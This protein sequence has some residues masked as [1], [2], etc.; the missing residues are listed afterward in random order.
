MT[1]NKAASIFT[2]KEGHRSLAESAGSVLD[3]MGYQTSIN[4]VGGYE[5]N[6]YT[7]FYQLF[8][9]LWRIPYTLHTSRKA[10]KMV[11]TYAKVAYQ[12]QVIDMLKQQKPSVVI[13]TWFILNQILAQANAHDSFRFY[14]VISDPRTF[15]NIVVHPEAV[16]LLF[17]KK[18]AQRAIRLGI[19]KKNVV[20][21]GWFVRDRFESNYDQL[22]IRGQL[23][24]AKDKL[25]LLIV[26]GSEG[27]ATILKILPAFV[28]CNRPVEVIVACGSSKKLASTITTLAKV[29]RLSNKKEMVSIKALGFTREVHLYMQAADLV[30]GKAGPNLLFESVATKTPFMA[31]THISGQEDGNLDIIREYKL[32][33]VEEEPVK[34]IKLLKQI[35]DKPEM[36]DRFIPH[37]E[38]LA[39]HNRGAKRILA[40]LIQDKFSGQ[41]S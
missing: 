4:D 6:L 19:P 3:S 26:A 12:D 20:V 10:K 16:N 24:L 22:T 38:K 1:T 14:N 17:D 18:A 32:G 23:G 31:I 34:A 29:I 7:P 40:D 2:T 35:L 28:N 37:L 39:E 27:T 8:P 25:I 21:S 41:N 9:Q 33:W 15:A 30:L 11:Q 36:L 5:F 13:S